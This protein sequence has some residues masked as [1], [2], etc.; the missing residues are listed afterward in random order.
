MVK[1]V[2][3]NKDGAWQLEPVNPAYEVIAPTGF[4]E[5]LG[6]VVGPFRRFNKQ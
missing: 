1:Y 3:T 2:G 5:V 6:V 4:L